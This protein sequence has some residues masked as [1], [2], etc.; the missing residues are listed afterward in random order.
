ML[1]NPYFFI[2]LSFVL[3]LYV[4]YEKIWPDIIKGLKDDIKK[5]KKEFGILETKK[6][7]LKKELK[8]LLSS[9]DSFK[10]ELQQIHTT[11]LEHAENI[12]NVYMKNMDDLS[13]NHLSNI[14]KIYLRMV[15]RFENESLKFFS[16]ELTLDLIKFFEKQKSNKNFQKDILQKSLIL[17]QK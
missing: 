15:Q 10:S 1:N 3:F 11:S 2:I 17:L 5:I 8:V 4:G 14:D 12:K 9:H 16:K 7:T 6:S 13:Q